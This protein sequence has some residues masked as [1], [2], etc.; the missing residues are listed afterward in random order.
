MIIK[1]NVIE[2][3][4]MT[5]FWKQVHVILQFNK[6]YIVFFFLSIEKVNNNEEN[7]KY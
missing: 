5:N 7:I 4:N 3:L 1:Q 2:A 6:Q